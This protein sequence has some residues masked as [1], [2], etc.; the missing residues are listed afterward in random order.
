MAQKHRA[1]HFYVFVGQSFHLASH[2]ET[3]KVI[4]IPGARGCLRTGM[5]RAGVTTQGWYKQK[6]QT[7][8]SG[9][10]ILFHW[11]VAESECWWPWWGRYPDSCWEEEFAPALVQKEETELSSQ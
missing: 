6:K 3:A 9:V 5:S 2:Y 4:H 7:Q 10:Q 11:S 8:S 1:A